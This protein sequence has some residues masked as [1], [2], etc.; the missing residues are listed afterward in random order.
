MKDKS[1]QRRFCRGGNDMLG[2]LKM[3]M[4]GEI[5]SW[6]IRWC[7][8]Q[9]LQNKYTV[10]PRKTMVINTGADGSGTNQGLKKESKVDNFHGDREPMELELLAP[11]KRITREFYNI[12]S[13]TIG[14]KIKRNLNVAGVIKQSKKVI[15]RTFGRI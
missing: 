13:D 9:S 1:M 5:D 11:D 4:Q 12:H 6:A 10:Y 15:D 2:M 14:K 7:F 8:A 3:Q